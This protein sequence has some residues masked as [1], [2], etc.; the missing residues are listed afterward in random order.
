MIFSFWDAADTCGR[1]NSFRDG[2]SDDRSCFLALG[3]VERQLVLK[4]CLARH[5]PTTPLCNLGNNQFLL[6]GVQ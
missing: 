1:K 3:K 5:G 2:L 4:F 6:D